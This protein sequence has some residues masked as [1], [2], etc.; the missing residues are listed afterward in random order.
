M[1]LALS[2]AL[3]LV[4]ILP[5]AVMGM[6]PLRESMDSVFL[7]RRPKP[8]TMRTLLLRADKRSSTEPKHES[9]GLMEGGGD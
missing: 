8:V 1:A 6:P 4:S 2:L 9:G 5:L 3:G 7:R